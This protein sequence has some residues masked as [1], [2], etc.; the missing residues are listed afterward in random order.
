MIC[1]RVSIRVTAITTMITMAETARKSKAF[2]L[3]NST[4]PMPPAPIRPRTVADRLLDS[5][6]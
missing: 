3:S 4:W 2:M 6:R 5:K 1:D